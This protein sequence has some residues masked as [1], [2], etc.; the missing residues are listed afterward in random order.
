MAKELPKPTNS[1]YYFRVARGQGNSEK[2]A[3]ENAIVALVSDIAK[4]E[5]VYVSGKEISSVIATSTSEK[6]DY[7]NIYVI[8]VPKLKL[9]FKPIDDFFE[10]DGGYHNYNCWVLFEVA[11]N[12]DKVE[13]ENLSFTTQYGA[14]GLWRSAIVPGWG[15][16][17]KGSTAKGLCILGGEVLLAG[18]IIATESMRASYIKKI[19]ETRNVSHIQ[20]Y[21]NKADNMENIRNICIGGAAA[22]Y[23]Y[24]LIDAVAAPGAR[25]WNKDTSFVP[26]IAPDYA[27]IGL[28]IN[29]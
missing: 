5:G 14:R 20:T 18:G 12:P 10:K 3:R 2:E 16:M 9:S 7:K 24:N 26:V 17:Y 21:A 1:S 15:Q 6:N 13:Y 19:G 29:F 11:Y 23:L 22:L 28:A 8:D 4:A 27:G 25:R